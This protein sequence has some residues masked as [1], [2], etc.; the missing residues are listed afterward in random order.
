MLTDLRFQNFKS[1][2]DTGPIRLAPLTGFFG[3]NS[4]GKSAILHLLLVLKQTVESSDR[5]RVFHTG[6]EY[7]YVDLGT[8]QE[9]V[10][11]YSLPAVIEYALSWQVPQK[12][13]IPAGYDDSSGSKLRFNASIAID[14]DT[15]AVQQL[16]YRFPDQ[17]DT[18]AIEMR[19]IGTS[20]EYAVSLLRG[21]N[22]ADNGPAQVERVGSPFKS[23]GFPLEANG[24]VSQEFVTHFEHLMHRIFYLGPLRVYPHRSYRWTGE[25]PQ[26]V[27]R[28]G[29]WAI[30]ALLAAQ[31]HGLRGSQGNGQQPPIEEYVAHW[32]R[33]LGLVH[34]FRLQQI[35]AHRQDYEVRVRLSKNSPEVLITDVGFGVSQILPVLA[36]CYYVPEGSIIVLEHPEM[37]LHPAVQ[38]GLADVLIDVVKTRNVQVIVESHSEYLMNRFQ[39]RIAEDALPSTDAAFSF[40]DIDDEGVS[41]LTT[42]ELDVYGNIA[43]WPKDFFGDNFGEAAAMTKAEIQRRK[44]EKVTA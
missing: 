11:G 7:T 30:P 19:R 36:L 22:T 16:G 35:A 9:V 2:R 21:L 14:Q 6:N 8:P 5:M 24:N 3:P 34:S 26:D 12:I 23:Y 33:E 4:S 28:R 38:M 1:W 25:R 31:K 44:A 39:R 18:P 37:H 29:E 17:Q 42:L 41:H 20:S 43:N 15:V 13:E 40:C 27:G 10:H 32:L